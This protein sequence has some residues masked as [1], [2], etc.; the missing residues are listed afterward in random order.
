MSRSTIR[1]LVSV[2]LATRNEEAFIERALSSL[3]QQRGAD[4]EI[5]IIDGLS[6]D[7]TLQ[8]I[9]E[10]VGSDPRVRLINNPAR[11]IPFAWNLGLR[12]AAGKYICT[13]GAHC[14][15]ASNYVAVCL[16]Q[17]LVNGA[18]G[19]GGRAI[20]IP[21]KD[22]VQARLCSWILG[23]PFGSSTR[24]FRTQPEG[25]VD[26][27]AY[28]IFLKSAVLDVGGFDESLLR[29]ED[30]DMS[31]KL[32]AAGG[33]LYCT[34]KTQSHYF[35]KERLP[36]LLRYAFRNGF[37][38]AIGLGKSL[39]TMGL[40]HFVPFALVATLSLLLLA[41]PWLEQARLVF[42]GLIGLHLSVGLLSALQIAV[43]EKT[44][45]ALLL[46]IPF[47]CFHLT[48]GAGTGW[49]LTRLTKSSPKVEPVGTKQEP[50]A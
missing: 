34:W 32:R 20:S 7:S 16:E 27:P 9:T 18:V 1:P 43:K 42:L 8:K 49:G 21:G 46:P 35:G 4:F 11:E 30:N 15:Y 36:D 10:I 39:H 45:S 5:L 41:S 48:Y 12:A 17:L 29:N 31:Q 22:S 26:S 47:L 38:N 44:W 37:W 23:H 25:W 2:L 33:R 19:C 50:A 6:T 40:R 13:F 3:L 14:I 28:P 24:S